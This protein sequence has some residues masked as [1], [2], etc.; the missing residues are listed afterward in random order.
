V[1]VKAFSGMTSTFPLDHRAERVAGHRLALRAG[2]VPACAVV[3]LSGHLREPVVKA[4]HRVCSWSCGSHAARPGGL[5][6]VV[7][8]VGRGRVGLVL[9]VDLDE[10]RGDKAVVVRFALGR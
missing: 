1:C 5:P 3:S 7:S 2:S 4:G 8:A 10:I 6:A 9:V